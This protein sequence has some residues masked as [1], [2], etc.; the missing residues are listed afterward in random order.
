MKLTKEK[1]DQ[2]ILTVM[3]TLIVLAATWYL[4]ISPRYKAISTYNSQISK[5]QEALADMN[6]TIA[7]AAASANQLRDMTNALANAEKDLAYGDPN[8][9][10]Y[11]TMRHFKT[12]YRIDITLGNQA[13]VDEVDILT[14][15][16][17]KQLRFSVNGNGFYHDLGRFVAD[18]ENEFPH[19][20]VVNLRIDPSTDAT[21]KLNFHMDIIALVKQNEPQS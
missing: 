17:Y 14:G 3:G 9:W 16:P 10:V 8:A 4:W 11:D 6:K 7:T 12:R 1:R 21:E 20:R 2:L 18:F 15:F 13:T 19:A 5:Q